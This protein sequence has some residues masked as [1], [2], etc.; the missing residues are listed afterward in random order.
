MDQIPNDLNTLVRDV[1][2]DAPG[3]TGSLDEVYRRYRRRRRGKAAV[4]G[5][6]ALLL[7][8]GLGLTI[9]RRP[10]ETP[11]PAQPAA[12][13]NTKRAQGIVVHGDPRLKGGVKITGTFWDVWPDQVVASFDIH[14]VTWDGAVALPGGRVVAVER[15][16]G[17]H[18]WS[19]VEVDRS[20]TT[21]LRRELPASKGEPMSLLTADEST[22]YVWHKRSL[23]A[24]DL[25]TGT[26][27][28]V[29]EIGTGPIQAVDYADGRLA[30]VGMSADCQLN[31]GSGK[32]IEALAA[33]MPPELRCGSVTD[34]RLSPD[35]KAIAVAYRR[36][37]RDEQRVALLNLPAAEVLA[38]QQVTATSADQIRLA[39]QDN[40]TLNGVVVPAGTWFS[41]K[42]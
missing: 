24:H 35:G 3:Y 28:P 36:M 40:R 37:D 31:L 23:V 19:L 27:R 18:T 9:D 1:A 39:W 42:Y 41:V 10:Q 34:L 5:V 21:L 20:G 4:G 38:D 11:P 13:Q 32:P 26:E 14:G 8:A 6:L 16:A 25:A 7:M 15:G 17:G 29:L 2:H 12:S 33:A 22:A 30:V